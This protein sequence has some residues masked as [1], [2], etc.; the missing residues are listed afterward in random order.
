MAH[1]S[2]H[3]MGAAHQE[4]HGLTVQQYLMIGG[5][6]TVVTVIELAVS[7]SPLPNWLLIGTLFI[8]SAFKFAMVAAYFMHLRFESGLMTRVFAGSFL[9]AVAIL[10]ALIALFWGDQADSIRASRLEPGATA[11][12]APH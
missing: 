6:L 1:A 8:L 5:I 7:Y 2:E 9:L 3:T 4:Q 12:A 11:T 10:L